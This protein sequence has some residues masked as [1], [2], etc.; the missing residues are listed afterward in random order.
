[1]PVP[2]LTLPDHCPFQH[3]EC[4]EQGPRPVALIIVRLTCGQARTQGKDRLRSVQRL[5]LTLLVHAQNQRLF[6]RV[7]IQPH[8]VATFRANWG[9]LLN[10]NDSTRCG[11]SLCFS[12]MRCTVVGLTFCAAAI[13]RTLHWVASFGGSSWVASTMA[14]SR[15]S[16][17]CLGR[18]LRGRSSRIPA[19][20]S[21]SNRLGSGIFAVSV[22]GRLRR[23]QKLK[24]SQIPA[25]LMQR[26]A[27]ST[28]EHVLALKRQVCARDSRFPSWPS[29][30]RPGVWQRSLNC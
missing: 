17:I 13:V 2:R 12:Q 6:W 14:A 7:H 22:S 5:D 23:W 19:M 24:R 30:L 28:R 16:E 25:R 21:L 27:A 15:S 29:A 26:M 4:S 3:V 11:C 1:M 10:L 9:S 8:D 20:P 18:P